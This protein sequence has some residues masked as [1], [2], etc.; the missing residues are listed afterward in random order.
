MARESRDADGASSASGQS[1][2]PALN[3]QDSDSP[4]ESHPRH[5]LHQKQHHVVGRL[6]ARAPSSKGLH[7]QHTR[8]PESR[9][10]SPTEHVQLPQTKRAS[11]HRRTISDVKLPR[12]ASSSNI[13]RN[14]SQSSL[15]RNRSHGDVHKRSKS[16][17]KLKR[18]SG[19]AGAGASTAAQQRPR[20]SKSQVHFD[21]GSDDPDDEGEWVDASGSNSPHMSRKGSINSS[22]QSSLRP[23]MSADNSRP[24]TPNDSPKRVMS[25]PDRER[26]N[27][28]RYLTTRL[29][30]RIPSN[31]APPQMSNHTAQVSPPKLSPDLTGQEA[32]APSTLPG[33]NAAEGLTSRFVDT[34][35]SG[36]TS[37]GSFYHPPGGVS[38][39]SEDLPRRPMSMANLS[40]PHEETESST[41][42]DDRDDS[43]LVPRPARRSAH[44]AEKSRIQQKLNLQRASS[45][46]EPGHTGPVGGGATT[47]LI[48]V[49]GPGYDGGTSRDPRVG[50]L[51]ERTGMEYLVVRRYQNPVARSLNRL[52]RLPDVDRTRRIPRVHTGSTISKRSVDLPLRH[53]RNVSMPD[54]RRPVTPKN[55]ASIRT[56][57]GSSFEGDD[58][59][60]LNERLSG[61][62]LVGSSDD[63]GTTAL[64]RNLWEKSMDL[65]AS[66]D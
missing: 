26:S 60:R 51:L 48:G 65:S 20:S 22:C 45:A 55:A 5:K 61:S 18:N 53:T 36:V 47:P 40:R 19:G 28:Q 8:R 64:L 16:T 62:S 24:E 66:G 12:Q 34:P 3:R 41:P 14:T 25:S 46:I 37:E 27:H 15:K 6:H 57:A 30:Q 35:A 50:K 56:V 39:R 42:V 17:D 33:S 32:S 59:S 44:P 43:A 38:R 29:L 21:L 11:S 52:G 4:S 7:K 63:D 1:K 31:G 2:R 58:E 13:S 9:P 23:A 10:A 54:P 49:G